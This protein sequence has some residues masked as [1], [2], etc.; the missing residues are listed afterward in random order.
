MIENKDDR[1]LDGNVLE[2]CDFDTPKID[3]Q[4]K[5]QESDY[6]SSDHSEF[7]A[8]SSVRNPG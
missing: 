6:D 3:P 5:S 1:R 8:R 2:A 4:R 7:T